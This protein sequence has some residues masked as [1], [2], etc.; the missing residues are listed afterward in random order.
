MS[1]AVEIVLGTVGV[2]IALDASGT[3]QD[4]STGSSSDGSVESALHSST[5]GVGS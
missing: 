5:G 4:K 3:S 1:K 2:V